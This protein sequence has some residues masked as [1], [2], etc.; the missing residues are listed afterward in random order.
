MN[1]EIS[2]SGTTDVAGEAP[3]SSRR[4]FLTR[5]LIAG[6]GVAAA[7]LISPRISRA[8]SPALT[9]ADIPGTGDVQVLNYALSL[10]DLEA[11]LYN[12][13]IMRLTEGGTNALGTVI[14]GLKLD[15]DQPDVQYL[16]EFGQVEIE[17]RNFLQSALGS[18]ALPLYKYDFKME[19]LHREQVVNLIYTAEALGVTAYLGAFP[20]FATRSYVQIASAIQGTEARHTAVVAQLLN[21]LYNEGLPVAPLAPPFASASNDGKD[22]PNTPDYVLAQV[23]GFI[24]T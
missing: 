23:S 6:A 15:S 2:Q 17:H 10:E 22:T 5:S 19:T 9:F 4:T 8:V 11:D 24:V 13:A 21:F 16:M 1:P 12:Q 14:P 20:F 18:S 3:G 7:G